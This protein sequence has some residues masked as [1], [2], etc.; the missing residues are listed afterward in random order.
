MKS[1][2]DYGF[3]AE[4]KPTLKEWVRELGNKK[5]AV[6]TEDGV[7]ELEEIAYEDIDSARKRSEASKESIELFL[8][9]RMI[10]KKNGEDIMIGE[11]AIKK[12]NAKTMMRLMWVLNNLVGVNDF[13]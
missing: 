10:K 7:F 9:S 2:S 12:F 5:Y 6:N 11:L 13:L 3:K 8:L 1:A 4:E